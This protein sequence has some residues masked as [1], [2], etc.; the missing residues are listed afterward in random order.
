MASSD[1]LEFPIFQGIAS[2]KCWKYLVG[3][4][5]PIARE[6]KDRYG[7]ADTWSKNTFCCDCPL[8]ISRPSIQVTKWV[9]PDAV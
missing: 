8:T 9:A 7:L 5:A 6:E 3:R 2:P 1:F 4:P